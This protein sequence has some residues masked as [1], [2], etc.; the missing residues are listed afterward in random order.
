MEFN[1]MLR[2]YLRIEKRMLFMSPKQAKTMLYFSK[3]KRE[4]ST[5]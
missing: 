4:E 2:K 3:E 1:L 5:C